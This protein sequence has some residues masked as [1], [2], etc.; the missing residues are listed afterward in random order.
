[1][2]NYFSSNAD[3]TDFDSLDQIK[4]TDDNDKNQDKWFQNTNAFQTLLKWSLL[5][6]N[7]QLMK[8]EFNK[9]LSNDNHYYQDSDNF[10]KKY[11][12]YYNNL[13]T[14]GKLSYD[15]ARTQLTINKTHKTIENTLNITNSK[16]QNCE[17]LDTDY[18]IITV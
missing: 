15:I 5:D 13:G 4:I 1:M 14:L 16:L 6:N 12:K 2:G 3:N 8:Y 11:S 10:D 17:V 18:C 9:E 7:D